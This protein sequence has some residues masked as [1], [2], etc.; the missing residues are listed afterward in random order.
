[1]VMHSFLTGSAQPLASWTINIID[2]ARLYAQAVLQARMNA[3]PLKWRNVYKVSQCSTAALHIQYCLTLSH[4]ANV[5]QKLWSCTMRHGNSAPFLT[6]GFLQG[7]C[8]LEYLLRNGSHMCV[9]IAE[10][11]VRPKLQELQTFE[12]TSIDGQDMGLNVRMR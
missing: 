3:P 5:V 12:S 2:R 9:R 11:E 4:P 8:V 10:S 1:M 6:K 7:L